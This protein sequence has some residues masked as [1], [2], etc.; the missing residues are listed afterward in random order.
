MEKKKKKPLEENPLPDVCP[1]CKLKY[2]N[3][4]T[5]ESFGSVREGMYKAEADPQSWIYKRRHGVLGRWHGLKQEL[6]RDH[7]TQHEE[8]GPATMAIAAD[9]GEKITF[10][11][12]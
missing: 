10:E 11:E 4:R 6:W 7:L 2:A 5:G 12:F 9:D 3:F 8:G 1:F